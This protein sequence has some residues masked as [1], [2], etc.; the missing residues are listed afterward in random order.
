MAQKNLLAESILVIGSLCV[1]QRTI[2]G[3]R[4]QVP[5]FEKERFGVFLVGQL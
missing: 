5:I 4:E 1:F 3:I 2:R